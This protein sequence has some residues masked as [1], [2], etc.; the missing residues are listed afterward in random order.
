MKKHSGNDT[1]FFPC[2]NTSQYMSGSEQQA[3]VK[4]LLQPPRRGFIGSGAA[5][6]QKT[7][8]SS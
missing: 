5:E 7:G 8:T 3:E 2:E 4:A 1:I 6:Q